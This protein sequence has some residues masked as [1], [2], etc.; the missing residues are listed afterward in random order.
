MI[1]GNIEAAL[2]QQL[3]NEFYSA[4]LYLSMAAWCEAENLPGFSNWMTVQNMEE[5]A[6]CMKF[7]RFI[8]ER[9]GKVTLDG[10]AVPPAKWDSPLNLFEVVLKHEEE[11]TESINELVDL[12]MKEKDH[13]TTNFLQWYIEEQVEEEA[14]INNLI[15][16]LKMV[17]DSRESLY[18]FD[19]ELGQRVFV[20]P[21]TQA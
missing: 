18:L 12:A 20:D 15:A 16:Q 4:Y 9:G 6:H 8:N 13:A 19:K 1:K 14:T 21:T 7:F 10:V 17:H 3:N 5:N 2:N 11:V